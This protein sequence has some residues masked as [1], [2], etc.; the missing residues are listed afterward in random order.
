[1]KAEPR[2][3]DG[4]D[5]KDGELPTGNPDSPADRYENRLKKYSS[6][7]PSPFVIELAAGTIQK[8]GVKEGDQVVFDTAG[9]KR[10][11]R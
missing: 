11:A 4:S 1:M 6:R 5:G 2:K 7:F 9:L 3:P 10:R 8:I